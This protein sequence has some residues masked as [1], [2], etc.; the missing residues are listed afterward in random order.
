MLATS[1]SQLGCLASVARGRLV[2]RLDWQ[3]G[4]LCFSPMDRVKLQILLSVLIPLGAIAY[5][6]STLG[7]FDKP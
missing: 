6:L 3:A 7:F 1:V 4:D 2:G 5:W